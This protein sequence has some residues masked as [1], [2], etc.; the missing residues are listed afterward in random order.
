ML[1]CRTNGLVF[2]PYIKH[3]QDE[4]SAPSVAFE[5]M[6]VIFLA[7]YFFHPSCKKR[8]PLD[9]LYSDH[10]IEEDIGSTIPRD[11]RPI[12]ARKRER[13]REVGRSAKIYALGISRHCMKSMMVTPRITS[14][15]P[16][17]APSWPAGRVSQS[18]SAA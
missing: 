18:S 16:W 2:R 6:P 14:L 13:A 5:F 15:A 4:N 17:G 7:G 10:G 8:T 12:K 1:L 3:V 11:G 9:F